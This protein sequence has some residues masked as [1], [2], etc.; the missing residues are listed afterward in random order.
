MTMTFTPHHTARRSPRPTTSR[1]VVSPRPVNGA[2][3]ERGSINAAAAAAL[4]LVIIVAF[5]GLGGG[6][7][8]TSPVEPVSENSAFVDSIEIYVVQPG[9]TLWAIATEVA[10][11]GEDIRPLVDALKERAG[12]SA[13]DVGQRIV[14]D[15]S[16]LR[17]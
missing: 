16:T 15:H 2:Q 10:L 11:P 7:A 9:D 13:L 1:A 17:G 8:A 5:V 4:A 14:I 6:A 3:A 12:G